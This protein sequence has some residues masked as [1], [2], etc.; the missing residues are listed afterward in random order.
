MKD[1]EDR[2]KRFQLGK[3]GNPLDYPENAVAEAKKR[4]TI[5]DE[6]D[7]LALSDQGRDWYRYF[8]GFEKFVISFNQDQKYLI[9]AFDL[10]EKEEYAK[11]RNILGRANPEETIR[12]YA[13]FSSQGYITQGEKGL[14]V[15]LNLRWL[16]DFYVFMQ[17]LRMMPVKYNFAPV[18][19]EPLARSA[20]PY[21]FYFTK[22]KEIWRSMG[23]EE[24]GCDVKTLQQGTFPDETAMS[25]IESDQ[26]FDLEL[27]IWRPLRRLETWQDNTLLPGKYEVEL[28][29]YVPG[30]SRKTN[31]IFE[32]QILDS[33]GMQ[34]AGK[35]V[36]LY[37]ERGQADQPVRVRLPFTVD[38]GQKPELRF[39]PRKG[40]II[41]NSMV[42]H[43]V[44]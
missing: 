38:P 10:I 6:I 17:K 36:N 4:L 37:K 20:G 44:E 19:H 7:T 21:T 26:A 33:N 18:F 34:V 24:T 28:M 40:S 32:L 25:W 29:F 15:S 16:P 22:E 5:L 42:I 23:T 41:L 9:D 3:Y 14:I 39:T 1:T 35:K 43:P 12:L 31:R 27:G 13:D 11:A 30:L 2:L 8:Y